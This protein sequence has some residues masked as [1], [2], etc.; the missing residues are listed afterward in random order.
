MKH[1]TIYLDNEILYQVLELLYR[2]IDELIHELAPEGWNNS[3]YH[4]PFEVV[5]GECEA[6]YQ[7]YDTVAAA[8]KGK[9]GPLSQQYIRQI[10]QY[11]LDL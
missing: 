5:D 8:Y 10:E 2:E 6:L 7:T 4:F 11:D 9:F 1:K 3:P